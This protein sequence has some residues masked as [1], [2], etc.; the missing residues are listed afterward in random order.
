MLYVGTS[1]GFTAYVHLCNGV[2]QQL[3]LSAQKGDNC[4]HCSSNKTSSAHD[5]SCC[6]EE[7]KHY[8]LEEQSPLVK[9]W[10]FPNKWVGDAIPH[11]F[12][13]HVFEEA[14]FLDSNPATF[15]SPASDRL[16]G[17]PLYIFHCTYLI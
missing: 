3:S 5:G 7:Q 6:T 17:N 16:R 13:G 4:K 8:K 12:F 1:S 14:Q 2:Q 10:D 9:Q 11:R 15:Y